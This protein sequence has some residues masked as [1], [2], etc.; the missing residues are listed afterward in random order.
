MKHFTHKPF[1]SEHK[2]D[3]GHDHDHDHDHGYKRMEKKRLILSM[4]ITAIVMIVEVAGGIMSNSM[5]LLSDA[6]HMFTHMF[7][8]GISLTAIYVASRDPYNQRTF[9]L[10]RVE[11]LAALFN[12]LFLFGV[13]VMIVWESVVRI[14]HVEEVAGTLLENIKASCLSEAGKQHPAMRLYRGL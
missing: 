14:M 3:H 10:Y 4:V 13:T 2:H 8:L 12:S 7:A 6:G 1:K 5:A 9:G 11:I